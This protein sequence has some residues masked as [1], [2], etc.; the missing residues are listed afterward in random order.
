MPQNDQDLGTVAHLHFQSPLPFQL[1][2]LFALAG[3]FL[4]TLR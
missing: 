4:S 2:K 3:H 1:N